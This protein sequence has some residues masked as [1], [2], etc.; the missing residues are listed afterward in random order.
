MKPIET[1]HQ[2][3]LSSPQD[4]RADLQQVLNNAWALIEKG[5]NDRR[6][7][8]HLPTVASISTSGLPTVR[9][10]VLRGINTLKRIL[11]FH[12]DGRSSK[13]IEFSI[14][15]HISVHFYDASIKTQIRLEATTILH[16]A[17]DLAAAAWESIQPN[18]R[19][20]YA[21]DIGPGIEVSSPLAAPTS[22]DA[23]RNDGYENFCLVL[24]TINRLEYL[25]LAAV[26]HQRAHF[27][28]NGEALSAARWLAP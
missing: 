26:G 1:L 22:K 18:S 10:V 14:N 20:C 28:W 2:S 6:S 27:E 12:T 11:Q 13:F 19:L 4:H 7:T 16:Q 8:F 24:A 9:T 3:Q 23:D 17:N 25:R 15:P 21:A 5:V